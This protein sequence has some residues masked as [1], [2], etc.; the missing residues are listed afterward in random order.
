MSL[1]VSK[2][3]K[4]KKDT[5]N[6]PMEVLY[7]LCSIFCTTVT[8]IVLSIILIFRRFLTPRAAID[9]GDH[10][11]LYQG[12]V[13]H[14]RRRPVHHSF[15]YS[16]RYAFIDLDNAPNPPQDHLSPVEARRISKTSGP[17]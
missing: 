11:T 5:K 12:M 8:S 16:V 4:E 7:L 10:V 13:W 2:I 3:H 1:F 6:H 15:Q 14:E 9:V 17:V